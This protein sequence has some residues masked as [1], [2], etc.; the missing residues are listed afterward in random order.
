M[1]VFLW[2]AYGVPE[3][4]IIFSPKTFLLVLLFVEYPEG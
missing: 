1:V 3:T 2:A 4:S